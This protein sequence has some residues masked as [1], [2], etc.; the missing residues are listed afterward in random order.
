MVAIE[1]PET[2]IADT[3]FGL[4]KAGVWLTNIDIKKPDLEDVFLSISKGN[5]GQKTH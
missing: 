1:L 4:S 3:L 2:G 5:Y